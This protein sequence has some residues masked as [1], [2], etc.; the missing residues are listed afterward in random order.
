MALRI[1]MQNP[2][3][4]IREIPK[5]SDKACT[6]KRLSDGVQYRLFV[7]VDDKCHPHIMKNEHS[8]PLDDKRL[9]K[10]GPLN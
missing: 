5:C 8:Y 6:D 10:I 4:K 7:K 1:C 9:S 2:S 3:K